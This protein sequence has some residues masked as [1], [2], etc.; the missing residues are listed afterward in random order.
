[1]LLLGGWGGGSPTPRLGE[2]VVMVGVFKYGF[3]LPLSSFVKEVPDFYHIAPYNISP[4]SFLYQSTFVRCIRV[5]VPTCLCF[6]TFYT[7]P[8][9]SLPRGSP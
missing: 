1:M 8:L 9:L 5:L 3:D 6:G 7:F 2:T 4:F